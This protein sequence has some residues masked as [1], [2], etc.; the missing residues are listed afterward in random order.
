M[1]CTICF[2]NINVV[3]WTL[4]K[5]FCFIHSNY[6]LHIVN[7]TPFPP[8]K[9]SVTSGPLRSRILTLTLKPQR[10]NVCHETWKKRQTISDKTAASFTFY[11]YIMHML[12]ISNY[13]RFLIKSF[14]SWSHYI[15]WHILQHICC[16]KYNHFPANQVHIFYFVLV[17]IQN[18][19]V[20]ILH[21]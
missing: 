5:Y 7:G 8:T 12:N 1:Q 3:Y 6:F 9:W 2:L 4:N 15:F 18:M 10:L 11:P 17:F 13:Y 16:Y 20:R 21:E 19:Y 14:K